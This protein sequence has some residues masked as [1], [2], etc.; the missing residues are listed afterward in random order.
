MER[1]KLR[2]KV[3]QQEFEAE[4]SRDT[5]CKQFQIFRL[6]LERMTQNQTDS[7][8]PDQALSHVSHLG[9]PLPSTI[10][11]SFNPDLPTELYKVVAP[12]PE[13][14]HMV[15][16][17]IPPGK[18]KKADTILLL[19]LGFRLIR[20]RQEVPVLI[21]NQALK[22]S[23]SSPARLDRVLSPYIKEKLVL[24][25]GKGKGGNYQLTN[26]GIERAK[27]KAMEIARLLP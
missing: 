7:S 20:N 4:G 16:K 9:S 14:P 12:I 21:L 24:K 15:C 18:R 23:G 8:A 13:T 3:N 5:V 1:L 26:D 6:L 11:N 17:V 27:E 2:I 25:S 22:Q 10:P 19:L